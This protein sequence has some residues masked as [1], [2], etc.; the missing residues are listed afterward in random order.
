MFNSNGFYTQ[1]GFISSTQNNNVNL[2]NKNGTIA[3]INDFVTTPAGT[4]NTPAMTIPNGALTTTPQNGAIERDS[5]GQLWETHNSIR[6]RLI[7]TSDGLITLAYKAVTSIQTNLDIATSSTI[8]YLS[9]SSI[10]GKIENISVQRLNSNTRITSL[11]YNNSGVKPKTAKIEVFLRINNGLF[12]NHWTGSSAVNQVKI[13]EYSGLNNYGLKNY[14]NLMLFNIQNS[15]P[16]LAQWS[17]VDFPLQTVN[18]G[19]ITTADKSYYLRD[20]AN[21]RT[22]GA[23]EASFSFV[24]INTLEFADEANTEG[25]NSRVLL[26]SDNYALFIE[27]IR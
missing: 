7:T 2:P 19:I 15:N 6:S 13:M 16:S 27:T 18:D 24:F 10:I 4:T 23:S 22:F 9:A 20:A 12:A 11:I 8:Q 14:Q 21:S 5:N 3:L 1:L 25:L 26:R 17:T